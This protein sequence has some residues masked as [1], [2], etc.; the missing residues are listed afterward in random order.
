MFCVW[1]NYFAHEQVSLF[2]LF[3]FF[4]FSDFIWFMRKKEATATDK[5]K[6]QRR[7]LEKK[8]SGGERKNYFLFGCLN[9]LRRKN[10]LELLQCSLD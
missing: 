6:K 5:K 3:S 10:H 1:I 4:F 2:S 7:E 8:K 9:L